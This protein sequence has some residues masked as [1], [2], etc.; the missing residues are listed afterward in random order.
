M[1][2]NYRGISTSMYTFPSRVSNPLEWWWCLFRPGASGPEGSITNILHNNSI[3]ESIKRLQALTISPALH[4]SCLHAAEGVSSQIC[5]MKPKDSATVTAISSSNGSIW[6]ILHMSTTRRRVGESTRTFLLSLREMTTFRSMA[7]K[8]WAGARFRDLEAEGTY[9][10]MC[11]GLGLGGHST[12]TTSQ[13]YNVAIPLKSSI[14]TFSFQHNPST[15]TCGCPQL[16][17]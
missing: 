7:S 17:G 4:E 10:R 13:D 16:V 1:F 9:G 2:F 5:L 11:G 14:S 8:N 15:Y 6:T 3:R 12:N